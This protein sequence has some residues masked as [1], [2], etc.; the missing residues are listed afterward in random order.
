[1]FKKD[2]HADVSSRLIQSSFI[3]AIKQT[4]LKV[5]GNPEL[6]PPEL[7]AD[8]SYKYDATIEISPEIEDLD[9]KGL[10]LERTRYEVS[11][12]EVDVQLKTLQ[13]NMARQRPAENASEKY[14]PAAENF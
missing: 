3:D 4:E 9:Y 10:N 1:M 8:S 12:G 13:K 6:E 5:I 14:G 2:V 7:T 11:D